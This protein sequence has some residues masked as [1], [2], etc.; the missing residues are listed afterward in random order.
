M[1]DPKQ[2]KSKDKL[3]KAAKKEKKTRVKKKGK[4]P[5]TGDAMQLVKS[6]DPK[7]TFINTLKVRRL[8][9]LYDSLN[10]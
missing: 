4:S 3:D 9:F 7:E 5:S 8:T 2:Q 10:E 1:T 6:E